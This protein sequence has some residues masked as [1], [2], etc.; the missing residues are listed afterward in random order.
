MLA[1][2]IERFVFRPDATSAPKELT[3]RWLSLTYTNVT[4]RTSDG[5][6]IHGWFIPSPE[7][8]AA[9]LYFHGNAG[10]CRDWVGVAPG[11]VRAGFHLFLVD[12]RGYGRSEGKPSEKGLYRDGEAA[13][14]WFAERAAAEGLPA[15][16]LGK[17]LGSA[18][19]ADLAARH[20]P[21]G[22]IL[23]SA[24]ASMREVVA[25]H[26]RPL[27]SILVPRMFETLSKAA[28]IACPTL[29]LHG[30]ADAIVPISHGLRL[31]EKLQSPKALGIIEG[32]GHND[33]NAFAPYHRWMID[34]LND[35][36]A[37]THD[38]RA[39]SERLFRTYSSA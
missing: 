25:L 19:A 35:P 13:W 10:D 31:Y 1:P 23:D 28:E 32:A 29:V 7:P 8:K 4:L 34:F 15:F 3:P 5:V 16:V 24:F 9:L 11:F 2:V 12:Y 27:P 39:E 37:V 26:A 18:V 17:S 22:L 33:L 20:A 38:R 30:D 6:M 14:T 21:A 36:A